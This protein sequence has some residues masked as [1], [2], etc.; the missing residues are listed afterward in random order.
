MAR[1]PIEDVR[2]SELDLDLLNVRIPIEGL[3]EPAIVNYLLEAA[4]LL[5]LAGDILRDGYLDNDVPVVVL[6][7]GRHVVLEGNRRTA[8]L[9][10]IH[11]PS[12]LGKSTA[13]L[14]RLLSRYPD[15]EMPTQIRV[16]VA[17][18]REAAQPLLARLHTRNPKEPWLREQQAVFYHAQLHAM[19]VDQLRDRYP[20]ERSSIPRFIRMG[21]MRKVIRGLRYDDRDLEEWVKDSKLSMSS[22]EYAYS[23]PKIQQ[24][25]GMVF[26]KDGLLPS[27]Q[28]SEGQRRALMYLLGRFRDKSLDT[29][30]LE[31]MIKS[32]A[33]V[34]F[35]EELARMAAGEA[36]SSGDV[37]PDSAGTGRSGHGP[38]RPSGG[39]PGTGNG[40]GTGNSA[41]RSG[42]AGT[43]PASNGA[44]TDDGTGTDGSA[45]AGSRGPNR[46]D[47][48][49]RLNMVSFVYRG[50]SPGL[51]R[52]FEELRGLNVDDFPNAAFD[53]LR[54]VLECAIK[55]HFASKGQ[56]LPPGKMLSY[57]IDQ[58]ARDFQN[59][60]RMTSLIN[61]VNRK[62]K[63]S[64]GQF[65][66]TAAALNAGNHEPDAFVER[67]DV[68]A[69]WDHLKP[70][71]AE[72]VGK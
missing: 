23:K 58:L 56:A 37:P 61:A 18:S 15:A 55:D 32:P 47:T 46:G 66:R 57:C 16:M 51:Q 48:K 41:S 69:A 36:D 68:H 12:L 34:D 27:T 45:Q 28:V 26:T 29:R 10:A 20:G 62:G 30:S 1:W 60:Q 40:S 4:D 22:L 72:I 2:L 21:E 9:K 63:L 64:A 3:D 7:K 50:T 11:N 8:A 24:A 17:P 31:L 38:G 52:R 70:I 53:L 33:H 59:D 54:T 13:R 65:A 5:G 44:G 25:L 49:S 67:Q 43:R 19:T 71:L 35:A 39:G 14:E 42:A 6:E